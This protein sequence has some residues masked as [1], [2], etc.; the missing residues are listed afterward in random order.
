M[1]QYTET[2]NVLVIEL[3]L[4]LAVDLNVGEKCRL[5]YDNLTNTAKVTW[6]IDDATIATVS[7]KGKVTAKGEGLT[8]ITVNDEAGNELGRIFVRVR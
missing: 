1:D 6:E 4:Q 5:T 3:E 2:I 7:S 8:Y